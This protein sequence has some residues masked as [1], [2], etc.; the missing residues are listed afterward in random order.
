MMKGTIK[1]IKPKEGYGFIQ[2]DTGHESVYF[3]L[4]WLKA[5]RVMEGQ[6]VEFNI[7]RRDRGLRARNLKVITSAPIAGSETETDRSSEYRFLN[8][9][10]FTRCLEKERPND[11]VLGNCQPPSRDRYVGMTGRIICTAEAKTPLFVS[12]S[13]DINEN[14]GH[15]TYRFFEYE[16]E[17][18]LPSSSLRGMLRSVFEAVTNSCYLT[19]TDKKLS[20]HVLPGEAI[21]LIPARVEKDGDKLCLRLLPG[22]NRLDPRGISGS[23]PQYAAWIRLYDPLRP[24]ATSKHN[25]GTDYAKRSSLSLPKGMKHGD[26]CTAIIQLMRHPP[27]IRQKGEFDFWNVEYI[28]KF[29]EDLPKL[30]AGQQAINGWLCITNQNIENKH[31]ERVFFEKDTSKCLPITDSLKR[32]YEDLIADYQNRHED[33]INKLKSKGLNV[34]KPFFDPK[35]G[36]CKSGFSR[37][38]YDEKELHLNDGDLVYAMREE[39]SSNHQIKFIVPVSIPRILY[40]NSVNRLL[41]QKSLER[42]H[43]YESLCPACRMFGWVDD[44]PLEDAKHTA[45]AS[46]VRLSHG[47]LTS[48][49]GFLADTRLAIL[50]APKP[51]T[52]SFYLLNKQGE[53]D[54]TVDYDAYGARLRGRKFYR[55]HDRAVPEEYTGKEP[56]EQNRTV[57]GALDTGATF[58][59]TV[60][61]EN[62]APLELGALIYALEMEEGMFHRLGYAKPLGFGSIKITVDSLKTIDWSKRLNS[63]DSEAGWSPAD[64][65][66]LRK[67][68]LEEMRSM[69]HNEFDNVLV[70][71]EKLLSAPPDL[72]IHYPRPTQSLD[73]D[74][75]QYEWFMGNKWRREKGF[76]LDLSKDD[77]KGLQLIDKNGNI[78]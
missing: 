26:P 56:T 72:P 23:K 16:K 75:P 22:T 28:A 3:R 42:C 38:I 60:E 37:F 69:Y 59:F 18:A 24:S 1:I 5:D 13:H 31:D 25:P 2:P 70:D 12:D 36:S 63:L 32:N 14:N 21:R 52:T 20:M 73:K 57:H 34:D 65:T 46:R 27:K 50:S 48:N 58:D 35:T 77:T 7:E 67:S 76:A 49:K 61:F 44:K 17:P 10:N 54:P 78:G 45:Y 41:K 39:T 29:G 74:H 33:I 30:V 4:S 15:K 55:H 71:L 40:N 62:L 53:P 43:N 51:T 8:P 6:K 11:K 64:K 68:F 66:A 9:Y 19:L 47:K